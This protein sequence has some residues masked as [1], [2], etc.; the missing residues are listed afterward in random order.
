MAFF[1]SKG[2]CNDPSLLLSYEMY[3]Q[4]KGPPKITFRASTPSFPS[5]L[6]GSWGSSCDP[7]DASPP[8]VSCC[9]AVWQEPACQLTLLWMQNYVCMFFKFVKQQL[10]NLSKDTTVDHTTKLA[11]ETNKQSF[12]LRTMVV[13]HDW[14]MSVSTAA[15][16]QLTAHGV[17]VH[18]GSF[19]NLH[20]IPLLPIWTF[21]TFWMPAVFCRN[22]CSHDM[23]PQAPVQVA[24][25][26]PAG[27]P[28][29]ASN[30]TCAYEYWIS[31]MWLW[32]VQGR[33]L[34]V[35]D[36]DLLARLLGWQLLRVSTALAGI[37][38]Q[39]SEQLS[40]QTAT[41]EVLDASVRLVLAITGLQHCVG[42]E[43]YHCNI[44]A[45]G[46][47]CHELTLRERL[48]FSFP[49]AD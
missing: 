33:H 34:Q 39:V 21:A 13:R 22:A 10:C 7:R 38:S 8:A 46:T 1:H 24:L 42:L 16:A 36:M 44:D 28:Q 35:S 47:V 19:S 12:T 48:I 37:S 18:H 5:S 3:R 30:K 23:S 49:C 27:S 4:A 17:I 40:E 9:V 41:I 45:R 25:S 11:L 14:C 31:C 32:Q 29:F 2:I 43:R 6:P 26:G 15:K 20:A